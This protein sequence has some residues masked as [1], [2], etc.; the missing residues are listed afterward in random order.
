[1]NRFNLKIYICLIS[2][3]NYKQKPKSKLNLFTGL[4][5]QANKNIK[6]FIF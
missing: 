3:N 2:K 6:A 1:M 4:N 5:Q